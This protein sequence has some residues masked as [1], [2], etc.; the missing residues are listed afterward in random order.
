[1]FRTR[2]SVSP[3]IALQHPTPRESKAEEVGFGAISVKSLA[4]IDRMSGRWLIAGVGAGWNEAEFAALGVPFHE[5]G[6]RSGPVGPEKVSFAGRFFSFSGTHVDPKPVH[7]PHP[8]IW[9]GGASD[10]RCAK[11]RG[12]LPYGSRLRRPSPS[13]SS[14]RPGCAKCATESGA[15]RVEF[16]TVAGNAPSS[17]GERS[18]VPSLSTPALQFG[19]AHDGRGI[20]RILEL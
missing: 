2:W 12:S 4:A 3:D 20:W 17:G 18:Y 9:I 10:A 19:S 8:P 11:L 16:S 1:M 15:C 14:V 13:W 5:R 6:A 7:Q